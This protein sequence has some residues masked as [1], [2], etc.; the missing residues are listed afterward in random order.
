MA[1]TGHYLYGLIRATEDLELGEI[2]LPYDGKPGRVHTLRVA[3]L[4]AVVSELGARQKILPL[5][6]NLAPHHRVIGE[7]MKTTTILP[8]TF[9]HVARS[10]AEI[11][12]ALRRNREAIQAQLDLVD[13]KVE[14][15]LRVRWDVENLFEYFLGIDAELRAHRDRLFGRPIAPSQA[16]QI[17][18]GQMF[19]ERRT[20]EREAQTAA[21]IELF[22]AR[23]SDVK[24][25]PTRSEAM[26]M[27]LAFLV[28]RG[29]IAAFEDRVHQVAG[30]FPAQYAFDYSGPWA[31]FHFVEL[32]LESV[33]APAGRG[34]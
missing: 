17:E 26:L 13:G 19:D 15:G 2:G 4:G 30:T 21:V 3:S 22:R 9:G 6:Q 10:E 25:N 23:Y 20:Q 31:P 1:S 8:M 27:D 16:E 33:A 32:D 11:A 7:V 34:A 12:R 14:M 24:V 5:R 29:G 28:E 18:L